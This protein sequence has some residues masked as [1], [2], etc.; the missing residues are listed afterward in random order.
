VNLWV[1]IGRKGNRSRTRGNRRLVVLIVAIVVF[2]MDKTI[3][4]L[5]Y[6]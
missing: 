5:P 4:V 2:R 1:K 3:K 6:M